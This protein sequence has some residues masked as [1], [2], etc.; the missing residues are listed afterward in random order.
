MKPKIISVA[1]TQIGIQED[2]AHTNRGEA[3]KYQRAAGL[4]D[5]GG[6]PWCQS[7]MVWCG[8]EA[9]GKD[10]PIPRVGGVLECLRLAKD[11]GIPISNIPVIGSQFIIDEGGSRGHTGLV[12]A[13]D[14]D[15]LT[16]IEG[17]SNPQG[18]RDGYAVVLQTK[19]RIKD[20]KCFI[21]YNYVG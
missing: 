4:G 14:G 7:F 6:Y 16:T 13:I 3:I 10:S 15:R 8:R 12:V 19:R 5:A 20:M 2:E 18:G 1:E 21:N 11:K 17:N 9:Y